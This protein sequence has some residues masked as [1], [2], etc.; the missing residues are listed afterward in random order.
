MTPVVDTKLSDLRTQLD[1]NL[2]TCFL[3]CREA[4]RTIRKTG[5][6]GRIVNVAARPTLVP[7]AGMLAYATAK[8]AVAGL[9][10]CLAQEVTGEGILVN[11]VVPSIMD[12]PAN[13]RAM[14][15]ADFSRWPRTEQVAATISFL[16]SFENA[17]TSGT[18]V[19]VYGRA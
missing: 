15:D 10:R 13:R 5:H 16:A 4:V 11:A 2:T 8:S 12:T 17:L 1:L 7:A 19:P 18:L 3:C 6:G 9:T 14:P